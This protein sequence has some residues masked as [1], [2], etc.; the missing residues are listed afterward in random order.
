M[1]NACGPCIGQWKRI[2]DD[3]THR[4]SI[5]TS[6]NRNFAKRA[7][8]NPNTHAFI[9]S[10]EVAVGY[11]FSGSLLSHPSFGEGKADI[12]PAGS[13]LPER[14]SLLRLRASRP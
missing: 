9:T 12:V 5:I 13:A 8:G 10:P 2:T 7:D 3:P 6:F 4:N 11:A 14:A 1:T